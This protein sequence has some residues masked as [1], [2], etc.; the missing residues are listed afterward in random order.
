[1][2]EP[3][4]APP[5]APYRNA[6]LAIDERLD[7]LVARMTL[8]EKAGQLFCSMATVGPGGTL[9]GE[10]P[11]FGVAG[12]RELVEDRHL[13]HVNI[14]AAPPTAREL[15][16]WHNRVQ[17]LAAATRLGIPV[18]VA[19]DP[20]HSF[21]D[22][23]ATALMSGP[24]SQWPEPL[25]LAAIGD[26][27]LV[28]EFADAVRREYLTV[29]IRTALHPQV[30]LATEP[31]WAR[32]SGTFGEDPELTARMAVA[33]VRGIQA[34]GAVARAAGLDAGF[35]RQSVSAMAKHFP[36]GGPQ[37]D[38][39][40][41]HFADGRE[42]VYPGARFADHLRPFEALVA[43]G[44]R[45]MMPYYGMPVG[46]TVDG[47][48]VPAV[49]FGF[50]RPVLTGLLRERLGFDG[51]VCTD[52]GLVTD[53]TVMG[54]L[55][56]ARAWGAEHLSRADRVLLILQAGADQLGGEACPEIVVG[57]VRSGR[58]SVERVDVS[59]RRL[60]REKFLLGLFD[61]ARYVDP[62]EAD[63]VVGSATLR[64]AGRAAQARAV[65]V[66]T[67]GVAHL[68]LA[69][70]LRVY[71]EGVD[72]TAVARHAT[73]VGSPAAAD[74]AVL[75]LAAPFEP[76]DGFEGFFHNGSLEFD[77]NTVEHVLQVARTVPSVVEVS[78][79]RPAV[80][81]PFVDDAGALVVTFGCSD[82]ALLDVLFGAV[83]PQGRL[84]FDLPQSMAAVVASR[85]DVPF[86][87]ADPLFR[88]GHG[89]SW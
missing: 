54:R 27:H 32:Q 45:Q 68:P 60:L 83:A 64:A 2:P 61:E 67:N 51:I 9:A 62:D 26:P 40:D 23:P 50:N 82:D 72:Q 85:P 39:K 84:P 30:D 81:T 79:D 76:A 73:V 34:T 80:L 77:A 1:M 48:A 31:R 44:V 6:H 25:G 56:P 46:L 3:A 75:R 12:V 18:T 71:A 15:A 8:E 42:Q 33:Y 13:T 17:E 37:L 78:C 53:A 63:R 36:G 19:S 24:F 22:N 86:D 20:R 69:A 88:F 49:G 10:D 41:P 58:L 16:E 21:T 7:D 43:A 47:E 11:V 65:T 28:E 5:G 14:L 55:Y 59:V 66:L 74:V 57:L 52:W 89:L 70:G 35:G 29:G 4:A 38:G 87:T